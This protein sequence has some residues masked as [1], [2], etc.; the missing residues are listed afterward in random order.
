MN[1][2]NSYEAAANFHKVKGQYITI[3]D[4]PDSLEK[5]SSD[6]MVVTI[7]GNGVKSTPG[8]PMGHQCMERQNS[9]LR[10]VGTYPYMV[11]IFR[12]SQKKKICLLG[13]YTYFGYTKKLMSTGFAYFE[14]KF[15]R[16]N[17][18][19]FQPVSSTSA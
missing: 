16:R 8:H 1:T 4:H 19:I 6:E 11:P 10:F 9:I 17:A 3:I 14:F 13:Y 5:V 2:F 15:Y 18:S 7:I 12:E